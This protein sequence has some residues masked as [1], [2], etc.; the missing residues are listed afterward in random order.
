MSIDVNRVAEPTGGGTRPEKLPTGPYHLK[1]V[2][3]DHYVDERAVRLEIE[4]KSGPFA[5]F[6]ERDQLRTNGEWTGVVWLHFPTGDMSLWMAFVQAIRASNPGANMNVTVSDVLQDCEFG[7]FLNS[8][9]F[10]GYDG[11]PHVRYKIL[12]VKRVDR[13]RIEG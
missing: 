6:F 5:G 11:M 3:V 8:E 2:G 13:E 10:V 4:V 1:I 12:N 7:A 9:D